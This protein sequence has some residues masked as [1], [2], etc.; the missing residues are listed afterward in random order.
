MNFLTENI[1]FLPENI[2]DL[3]ST[4]NLQLIKR[5]ARKN[6][7]DVELSIVLKV[8]K[9]LKNKDYNVFTKKELILLKENIGNL[10]LN[11]LDDIN[12]YILL[13]S[14]KQKRT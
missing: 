6:K 7:I 10:F 8:S 3:I 1:T 5:Y 14:P 2:E 4:K 9:L 13:S 11:R 12:A